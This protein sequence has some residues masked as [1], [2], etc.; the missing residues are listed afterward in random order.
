MLPAAWHADNGM[1]N[2]ALF[3]SS[4]PMKKRCGKPFSRTSTVLEVVHIAFLSPLNAGDCVPRLQNPAGIDP[5]CFWYYA[6]QALVD[7]DAELELDAL[8][9]VEP[10]Q[11][12]KESPRQPPVALQ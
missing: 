7:V 5:S 6:M 1:A 9:N 3:V 8:W 10:V 11:L 4:M 2:R 12:I